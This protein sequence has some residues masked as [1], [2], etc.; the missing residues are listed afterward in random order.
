MKFYTHQYLNFLNRNRIVF[1]TKIIVNNIK[2]RNISLGNTSKGYTYQSY[3][4]RKHL[5]DLINAG[6]VKSIA[7]EKILQLLLENKGL[8]DE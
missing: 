4:T 7:P 2:L 1:I 8:K 3:I 6:I 5:Q